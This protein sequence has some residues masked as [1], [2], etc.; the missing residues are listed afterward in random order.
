[1][2][3][4]KLGTMK[5]TTIKGILSTDENGNF[6]I[7]TTVVVQRLMPYASFKSYVGR[8]VDAWG[9]VE[10][11]HLLIRDITIYPPQRQP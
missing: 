2:E 6:W 9:T 1:M 4:F 3:P 11:H 5:T 7:D 10:N 8:Y